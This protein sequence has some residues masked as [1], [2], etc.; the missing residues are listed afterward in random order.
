MASSAREALRDF[1]R[2]R[3]NRVKST[4]IL[5]GV[6]QLQTPDD[7]DDI[8]SETTAAL[9]AADV[10][11]QE[12]AAHLLGTG[13]LDQIVD[14]HH[15]L[16]HDL[17]ALDSQQKALVYNNY[18]KFIK[19]SES[20]QSISATSTLEGLGDVAA[21]VEEM[22]GIVANLP[23]ALSREAVEEAEHRYEAALAKRSQEATQ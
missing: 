4:D 2:L 1:Y 17:K 14:V 13:S 23:P 15:A 9:D 16:N 22:S 7:E 6:Q 8:C 5:S 18:K 21:A 20:L 10:D 11:A 12:F 19:A 3:D